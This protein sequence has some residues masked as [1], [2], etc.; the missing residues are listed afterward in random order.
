MVPRNSESKKGMRKRMLSPRTAMES[1]GM[2][3]SR[4]WMV[5]CHRSRLRCKSNSNGSA[6]SA[7][8]LSKSSTMRQ[9]PVASIGFS[10]SGAGWGC[11]QAATTSKMNKRIPSRINRG[12]RCELSADVSRG[13]PRKSRLHDS[14]PVHGNR[15]RADHRSNLIPW[16]K[17]TVVP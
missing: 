13:S 11:L 6:S 7:L 17:G 4:L 1:T 9:A 8:V 2:A 10:A 3:S 15:A 12:E 16:A 5:M 14:Y